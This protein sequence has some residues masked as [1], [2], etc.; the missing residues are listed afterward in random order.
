M[1]L[2]S[3]ADAASRRSLLKATAASAAVAAALL[4]TVVLP[5]EYGIDPTGIGDRLGLTA[6]AKAATPEAPALAVPAPAAAAPPVTDRNAAEAA[7]AAS[8]FGADEGQSFSAESLGTRGDLTTP[9]TESLTVTL[10]PG[11][12]AEVKTLLEA[13]DGFVFQ[14][15]ASAEVAV[16]MHGERPG[17]KG[18]WTSYSIEAAQ[19]TGAGT[20]IAP[21]EGSH[22]WY[23]L[24]RGT[25]PVTVQVDVTGFQ[26]ALYQ[27]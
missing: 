19:R 7:K 18:A 10:A 2:V 11:K 25:S 24:N 4:V 16:D 6:L 20:F 8:V 23:W 27:P 14:W 5:A 15:T 3:P 26:S 12:G 21:F 17:V 9:K 22:G 1:T 13:G